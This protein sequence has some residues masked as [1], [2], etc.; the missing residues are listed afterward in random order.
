M[1]PF[2]VPRSRYLYVQIYCADG[3]R[4]PRSTGETNSKKAEAKGFEMQKEEDR[5][6]KANEEG[7]R[8]CRQIIKQYM[9][10]LDG[11]V[12]ESTRPQYDT[13]ATICEEGL[14]L[15]TDKDAASLNPEAINGVRS[16]LFRHYGG[17]TIE[18]RG[19]FVKRL[20]K[21]LILMG[22]GDL[23]WLD[24][25][26]IDGQSDGDSS[27]RDI[28]SD[29]Q[30]KAIKAATTNE[31]ELAFIEIADNIGPRIGD[32]VMLKVSH[33]NA[34]TG[35]LEYLNTKTG[36]I[37]RVYLLPWN[38]TWVE[39][40]QK[41]E[42]GKDPFLF[43]MFAT[44]KRP[45]ASACAWFAGILKKA[46]IRKE[47]DRV[48]RK[49]GYRK[50]DFEEKRTPLLSTQHIKDATG[51]AQR[52]FEQ[53]DQLSI[54]LWS[55]LDLATQEAIRAL[56]KGSGDLNLVHCSLVQNLNR[57]MGEGSIYTPERF[58]NVELAPQTEDL[59]EEEVTGADEVVLN[60][61]LLQDAYMGMLAKM[62]KKR[63]RKQTYQ[64]VFHSFRNTII[65]RLGSMGVPLQA[66]MDVIGHK[67]PRTTRRYMQALPEDNKRAIILWGSRGRGLWQQ[68]A[69]A[70]MNS[71]TT[72]KESQSCAKTES[73]SPV[74]SPGSLSG[75]G[76]AEGSVDSSKVAAVP[77]AG[78]APEGTLAGPTGTGPANLPAPEKSPTSTNS[79]NPTARGTS[80]GTVVW[81][82]PTPKPT[83]STTKEEQQAA[84]LFS[85]PRA[86]Y[87]VLL[88]SAGHNPFAG[89]KLKK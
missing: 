78:S 71:G 43:P 19:R 2:P 31:E 38:V 36:K 45:A 75:I 69:D 22:K 73:S 15:Y 82:V 17:N 40:R 5:Q 88:Q 87:E 80:G 44:K 58:D 46:G 52:L 33:Y 14:G 37:C 83:P 7:A 68:V 57:I 6:R 76:S 66:I 67:D 35:F 51:L 65:S 48:Q 81:I 60:R 89:I 77:P 29:D 16:Y 28:Y 56:V 64:H 62:Q 20:L 79:A 42:P 74:N 53:A 23:A 9:D 72:A 61:L 49:G 11:T 1:K 47:S 26:K 30:L 41:A 59:L 34:T 32:E 86:H 8:T 3:I 55:Q 85:A 12:T 39:K 63:G 50:D 54:F 70:A 25:F 18:D 13:A 21:H 4:R 84:E 10:D 27:P 24:G